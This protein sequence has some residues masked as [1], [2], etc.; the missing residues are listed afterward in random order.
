MVRGINPD[1]LMPNQ[2]GCEIEAIGPLNS[3]L[4][5]QRKKAGSRLLPANSKS[6]YLSNNIT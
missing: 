3:I 2:I 1:V 5:I 4:S 6:D